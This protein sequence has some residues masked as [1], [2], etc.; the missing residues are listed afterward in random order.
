PG[1]VGHVAVHLARAFGASVFANVSPEKS[2]IVESTESKG[3]SAIHGKS[4]LEGARA[5]APTRSTAVL[6]PASRS[7][8]ASPRS[9]RRGRA[10]KTVRPEPRRDLRAAS[11]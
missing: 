9:P 10:L 11:R 2:N 8:P 7:R 5:P 3:R 4:V 1:G 6:T